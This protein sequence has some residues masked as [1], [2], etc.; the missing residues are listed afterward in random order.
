[1]FLVDVCHEPPLGGLRVIEEAAELAVTLSAT[2]DDACLSTAFVDAPLIQI[3]V[4][5]IKAP[6]GRWCKQSPRWPRTRSTLTA[7]VVAVTPFVQKIASTQP[8]PFA[9]DNGECCPRCSR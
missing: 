6:I 5:V 2:Q 9:A 7:I 4:A 8:R 1:M 3:V